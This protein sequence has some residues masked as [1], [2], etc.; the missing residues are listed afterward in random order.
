MKIKINKKKKKWWYYERVRDYNVVVIS[1]N[2]S[3][4]GVLTFVI[5]SINS[6][7]RSTFMISSENKEV[8]GVFDFVCQ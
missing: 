2:E 5:E 6:V 1:C 7:N 3:L 8:L 4:F